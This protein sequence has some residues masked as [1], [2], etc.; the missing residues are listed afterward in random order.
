MASAE[1]IG[2][3]GG[4]P[5]AGGRVGDRFGD[6]LPREAVA[7]MDNNGNGNNNH[8]MEEVDLRSIEA[9][10]V[11][12]DDE[13][14]ADLEREFLLQQESK[15]LGEEDDCRSVG[16]SR[17]TSTTAA[18]PTIT[19]TTTAAADA[20]ED[21]V[22][23]PESDKMGGFAIAELPHRFRPG[24]PSNSIKCTYSN[25]DHRSNSAYHRRHIGSA[26][27]SKLSVR[28]AT[29][30]ER[31]YSASST[32]T[33]ES[34]ILLGHERKRSISSRPPREPHSSGG[35][36]GGRLTFSFPGWDVDISKGER[37]PSVVNYNHADTP[38][39]AL[40]LEGP[41]KRLRDDDERSPNNNASASSTAASRGKS[42][43]EEELGDRSPVE[44][45][46]DEVLL[47]VMR[48]LNVQDLC[49]LAQACRRWY[50]LGHLNDLWERF[51]GDDVVDCGML[52]DSS[53]S[54]D[55]LPKWVCKKNVSLSEA[56]RVRFNVFCKG[57]DYL[58]RALH[59]WWNHG[60]SS[61]RYSSKWMYSLIRKLTVNDWSLLYEALGVAFIDRTDRIANTLLRKLKPAP[62]STGRKA[63][64]AVIL[65]EKRGESN[66]EIGSF[67]VLY[68]KPN[69][70]SYVMN[71][72]SSS[73]FEVHWKS[74]AIKEVS[75]EEGV[76]G[77]ELWESLLVSWQKYKGWLRLVSTLCPDLNREVN[78]ERARSPNQPATPTVYNK[79]LISFRSQVVLRYGLRSVLQ[80]GFMYLTTQHARDCPS[81]ED[82]G[83]LRASHH[84]L[85]ELDVA[86]D[87]TLPVKSRTQ[88]KLRQCFR[89]ALSTNSKMALH[90]NDKYNEL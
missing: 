15:R 17:P 61:S 39:E 33:V 12:D 21:D 41:P 81:D 44:E 76:A 71:Y 67:S 13:L 66:V 34:P 56:I 88:T 30:L 58:R 63:S 24:L 64:E 3:G 79:G 84:M 1:S 68:E 78:I 40:L 85:Q 52:S 62:H 35:G 53:L 46:P 43:M 14:D 49:S 19:T 55:F 72:G 69:S 36:G 10:D 9:E 45:L 37:H 48:R 5:G 7:E 59:A 54:T 90:M 86:D 27:S 89:S 2:R 25:E 60:L 22:D 50:V 65:P 23:E 75:V 80:A 8:H 32:S 57:Y 29:S 47:H 73:E 42:A 51:L 31:Q 26:S 87:F 4:G 6:W 38:H 77:K 28:T 20:N 16:F 18:T 83:L 11:G 70:S 82:M 74:G